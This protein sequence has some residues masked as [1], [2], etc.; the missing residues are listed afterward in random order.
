MKGQYKLEEDK[1]VYSLMTKLYELLR[2]YVNLHFIPIALTHDSEYNFGSVSTPVNPRASQIEL[3]PIEAV[4]PQNQ[5]YM[6]MAD[7]IYSTICGTV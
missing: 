2:G 7:C 4:H 1:K 6:Q 3:L 5:G